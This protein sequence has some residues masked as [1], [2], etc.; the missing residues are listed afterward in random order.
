MRPTNIDDLCLSTRVS[1]VFRINNITLEDIFADKYTLH[2][3]YCLPYLG[4]K[5]IKEIKESFLS[6]NYHFKDGQRLYKK[7]NYVPTERIEPMTNK[8]LWNWSSDADEIQDL[9]LDVLNNKITFEEARNIITRKEKQDDTRR[10]IT[11][12]L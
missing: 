3:L 2:D 8:E 7:L 5:S 1:N 4:K 11:P 9:F 6:F 12:I 10:T